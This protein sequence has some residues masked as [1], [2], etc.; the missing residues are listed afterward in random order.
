MQHTLYSYIRVHV[1]VTVV[2]HAFFVISFECNVEPHNTQICI[3]L[4][5]EPCPSV[6]IAPSRLY[7]ECRFRNRVPRG[8]FGRESC[9]SR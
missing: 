7:D 4:Q 8:Q 2:R 3:V 6:E 1:A 5:F 9:L